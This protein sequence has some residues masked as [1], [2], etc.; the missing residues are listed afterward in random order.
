MGTRTVS[1]RVLR[2]RAREA[3][4]AAARAIAA[5]AIANGET[6]SAVNTSAMTKSVAGS[7]S[8]RPDTMTNAAIQASGESYESTTENGDNQ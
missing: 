7:T 5:A 4:R 8:T 3:Q 1:D 6:P 2:K